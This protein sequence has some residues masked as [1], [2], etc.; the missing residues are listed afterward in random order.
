MFVCVAAL[1]VAAASGA[2]QLLHAAAPLHAAA[3]PLHAAPA[4]HAAAAGPLH[5]APLHTVAGQTSHQ[6]V[7]TGAGEVRDV[8]VR[9]N[10]CSEEQ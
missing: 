4:L 6:S 3:G 9:Y 2:P 10:K 8:Q 1:L 7:R 5:A